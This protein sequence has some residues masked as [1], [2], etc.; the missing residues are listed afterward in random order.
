[1]KKS[2]FKS[3]TLWV[4][5]LLCLAT[6]LPDFFNLESIKIPKDV[7]AFVILIVNV[8]LRFMT[9]DALTVKRQNTETNA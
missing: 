3:K 4:N 8:V 9:K 1:M 2:I 7:A 6:V 5:L